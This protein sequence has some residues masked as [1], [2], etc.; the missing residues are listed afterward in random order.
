[1]NLYVIQ[2]DGKK[3]YIKSIRKNKENDITFTI[4]DDI[5]KSKKWKTK[6][7]AN[8]ILYKLIYHC[9]LDYELKLNS[10]K[11]ENLKNNNIT[12]NNDLKV[13]NDKDINENDVN[14]NVIVKENKKTT[15]FFNKIVKLVVKP[16]Y[17]IFKNQIENF[18]F[19]FFS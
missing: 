15:N 6:E 2:K 9:D 1:M 10:I 12:N 5:K 13:D 16:L 14:E 3:E 7:G 8:K 19:Y 17:F 11:E 18:K 4:T